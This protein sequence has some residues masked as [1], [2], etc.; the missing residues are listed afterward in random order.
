VDSGA[1]E[2]SPLW[3]ESITLI[4]PLL[5]TIIESTLTFKVDPCATTVGDYGL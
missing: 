5:E 1:Y 3:C 4:Y 2:I